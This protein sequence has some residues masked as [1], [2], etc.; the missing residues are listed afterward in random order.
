MSNIV[1]DVSIKKIAVKQK[2]QPISSQTNIFKNWIDF[3]M[4]YLIFSRDCYTNTNHAILL[5]FPEMC[6]NVHK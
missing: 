3:F 4:L 2:S 5:D 6:M 1:G